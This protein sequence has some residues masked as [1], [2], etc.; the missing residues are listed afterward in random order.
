MAA[1]A[2]YRMSVSDPQ[3]TGEGTFAFVSYKVTTQMSVRAE[4]LDAQVY[5]VIRRFNDF[6]WLRAQ[7]RDVCP[8]VVEKK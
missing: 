5:S 7:L 6:V 8:C 3:K 2:T 1:P 4:G